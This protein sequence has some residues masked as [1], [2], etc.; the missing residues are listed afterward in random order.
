M[1]AGDR[2]L[3]QDELGRLSPAELATAPRHRLRLVLDNLRSR[4]NVGSLFR[5]A[6]AFALE[7]LVLCGHTPLPPHR[8]IEKTALGATSTVPWVQAPSAV[9]AVRELRRAGY[10]VLALEQTLDA[11]PL[12]R[13][14]MVGE[15]PTALVLGNELHGVDPAVV[16]NSDACVVLPQYGGKHSLNVAVCAGI[17]AWWLAGRYPPPCDPHLFTGPCVKRDPPWSAR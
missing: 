8:E 1:S 16:E 15:V 3:T 6:D 12:D 14:E 13:M 7:G 10:R 9:E 17:A 4:H 5:T 2:K 11:L